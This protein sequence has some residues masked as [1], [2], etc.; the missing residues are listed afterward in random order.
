MGI[1]TAVAVAQVELRMKRMAEKKL[2]YELLRLKLRCQATQ[3]S[4]IFV[5]LVSNS[6]LFTEICGH[7]LLELKSVCTVDF[8]WVFAKQTVRGLDLVLR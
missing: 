4:L 1:S 6:Q 7:L 3:T 2:D 8:V 5:G